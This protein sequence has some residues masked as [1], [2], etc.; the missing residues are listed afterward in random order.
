MRDFIWRPVEEKYASLKEVETEWSL[1]DLADC[2]EM[3]DEKIE[4]MIR[5]REK[6]GAK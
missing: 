3:I 1:A 5:E 2:H 6:Q 4:R